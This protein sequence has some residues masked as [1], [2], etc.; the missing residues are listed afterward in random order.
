MGN[1][2]ESY[3]SKSTN[4][5]DGV[6]TDATTDTKT[7]ATTNAKTELETELTNDESLYAS[8]VNATYNDTPHVNYKCIT[9]G[10]VIKV[11]D[12]DTLCIATIYYGQLSK[13]KLRILDINTAELHEKKTDR[14]QEDD[15]SAEAKNER[16]NLSQEAKRVMTEMI[17]GKMVDLEIYTGLKYKN[18]IRFDPYGRLLGKVYLNGMNIAEEMIRRGLAVEYDGGKKAAPKRKPQK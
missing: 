1:C 9:K 16:L 14:S 4:A 2:I 5:V 12:G 7:N 13:F 8:L 10:K 17:D 11:T 18:R 15:Q 6:K 3:A